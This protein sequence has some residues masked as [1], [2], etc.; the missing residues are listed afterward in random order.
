MLEK[1]R[2]NKRAWIMVI[3]GLF[4]VIAIVFVFVVGNKESGIFG[5]FDKKTKKETEGEFNGEKLEVTGDEEETEIDMSDFLENSDASEDTNEIQKEGSNSSN[6]SQPES[7]GIEDEN[8]G[9]NGGI[10]GEDTPQ[11]SPDYGSFF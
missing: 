6:T 9:N 1:L 4:L 3:L 7:P 2:N 8:S 5:D 10:S 11:D